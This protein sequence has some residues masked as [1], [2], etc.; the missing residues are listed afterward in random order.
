MKR[1]LRSLS[2]QNK[3]DDIPG[4]SRLKILN[5]GL[6]EAGSVKSNMERTT[7]VTEEINKKKN[8]LC[9]QKEFPY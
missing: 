4:D 1:N 2:L 5:R 9:T 3:K 8:S 7:G 6:P